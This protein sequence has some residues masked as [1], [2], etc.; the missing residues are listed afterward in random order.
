LMLLGLSGFF[1][2]WR[3]LL[4]HRL[5]QIVTGCPEGFSYGSPGIGGGGGGIRG[6]VGKKGK[7]VQALLKSPDYRLHDFIIRLGPGFFKGGG[8]AAAPPRPRAWGRGRPPAL[9]PARRP[10][11]PAPRCFQRP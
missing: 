9:R 1:A 5:P 6:D 4:I 2:G 7:A 8:G 3:R 11:G 10:A